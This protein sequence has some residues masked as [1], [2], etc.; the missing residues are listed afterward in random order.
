MP[1]STPPEA[2]PSPQPAGAATTAVPYLV[3]LVTPLFFA[4]NLIFGRHA[5]PEVAPFT[6]AFLRWTG[7]ALVLLPWVLSSRA[8][9]GA[10]LGRHWRHWLGLGFLGMWVCG[11]IVYLA[12]E[13]TTATNGTL[14]YT[15]S[16]L[17]ILII[18]RLFNGRP[19]AVREGIGIVVGFLGVAVIVLRGD[20]AALVNL[21]PNAGDLL[22]IAAALSWAVYSVLLKGPR[23][24]GLPVL[25]LF[26]LVAISGAI[27]LAPMAAY[28]VV[29]GQRMPVTASAWTGI[30]GIIVFSSLLAFSGFQY[31]ISRLGASTAGI[32]MY[33]LPPYGVALAVFVLGEPFEAY[34]AAG[35]ATVLGGL[36]LATA[37]RP[38]RLRP[39]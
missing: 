15:T 19:I 10:Y 16:P 21:D 20:L 39:A 28:E 7:A 34:H 35:I 8:G 9:V 3:M 30:A 13:H 18:E 1:E 22:F 27:L 32:F 23:T 17:M 14:I 6:L 12:L 38:R 29:S 31:G 33:L 25:T 11:G 2:A 36:V 26:G 37:K 4:S 5:I 24:A